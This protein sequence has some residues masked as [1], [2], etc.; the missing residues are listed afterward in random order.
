M[1]SHSIGRYRQRGIER[2]T[3][4]AEERSKFND[5]V[6]A[7]C[8]PFALKA[9]RNF[10]MPSW[11]SKAF[12]AC[13]IS[14]MGF[15]RANT[16]AI[17]SAATA[18]PCDTPAAVSHLTCVS[19]PSLNSL[20]RRGLHSPLSG[21]L[22]LP[23]YPTQRPLEDEGLRPPR[24]RT[25]TERQLLLRRS[26]TLEGP[27]PLLRGRLL[28]ALV[29]GN[30]CPRRRRTRQARVSP[31]QPRS[32]L[33]LRLGSLLTNDAFLPIGVASQYNLK[34]LCPDHSRLRLQTCAC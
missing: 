15:A 28:L 8:K 22:Q 9:S 2:I 7:S 29:L 25:S 12:R 33:L 19:V 31:I 20:R 16:V 14:E 32:R 13:S 1:V 10:D 17:A 21:E 5:V 26:Q 4:Q 34:T 11:F 3:A 30:L 23:K 6:S 27:K 18:V 24:S